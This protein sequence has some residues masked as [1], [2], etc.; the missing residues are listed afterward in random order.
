MPERSARA[1]NARRRRSRT[2]PRGQSPPASARAPVGPPPRPHAK[3]PTSRPCRA[4]PSFNWSN[5]RQGLQGGRD[6]KFLEEEDLWVS[7]NKPAGLHGERGGGSSMRVVRARAGRRQPGAAAAAD[8]R[9]P[10]QAGGGGSSMGVVQARAAPRHPGAVAAALGARS[11]RQAGTLLAVS[12]CGILVLAGSGGCDRELYAGARQPREAGAALSVWGPSV[13]REPRSRVLRPRGGS[14]HRAVSPHRGHQR[15]P[16]DSSARHDDS[17]RDGGGRGERMDL[18]GDYA[19]DRQLRMEVGDKCVSILREL[20][21]VADLPRL[22]ERW[23]ALY[24]RSM[25]SRDGQ[26]APTG[27]AYARP[28]ESRIFRCRAGQPAARQHLTGTGR[29]RTCRRAS[30]TGTRA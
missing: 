16:P 2:A 7:T 29:A 11:P 4:W 23:A 6:C 10:R 27:H 3:R 14:D 28:R 24:P 20:G 5:S 21:G 19:G 22:V 30:T 26:V 12:L 9:R 15:G 17:R 25:V 1:Q 13:L 18:R 8:A